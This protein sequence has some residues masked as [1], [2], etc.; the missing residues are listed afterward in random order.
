MEGNGETEC[1]RTSPSEE[2][3][4]DDEEKDGRRNSSNNT[5][6]HDQEMEKK[7][8]L[9]PYVRSKTPR[10]RWT[11]DL[12][13]RFLQAVERVG[14]IDRATPKLV[15]QL[16]DMRGLNIAHVKSHLQMY[17]SKK[18]DDH[19]YRGMFDNEPF[20]GVDHQNMFNLRQ[21]P[22]IPSFHQRHPSK[23]SQNYRYVDV[24]TRQK[25]EDLK[26]ECGLLHKQEC[27]YSSSRQK[28]C[29]IYHD[30][31]NSS[32]VVQHRVHEQRSLSGIFLRSSHPTSGQTSTSRLKSESTGIKR[33]ATIF[34]LDLNLSLGVES[35]ND[36]VLQQNGENLSL[37]LC[38]INPSSTYNKKLKQDFCITRGTSTLDLTL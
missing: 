19:N 7:P 29:C 2:N 31:S 28:S 5:V 23:F 22:L 37:S 9:R 8:M 13:L 38:S 26:E 1:S 35:R 32:N 3:N 12:H 16:M 18:I 21:L 14:G 6:D 25:E 17:R 27:Q 15:L 33:K 30:L 4:D 11:T 36:A 20:L 24:C 10:L 34:E